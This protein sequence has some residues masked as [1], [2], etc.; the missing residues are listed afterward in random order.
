MPLPAGETSIDR[1]T[2]TARPRTDPPAA[3][4]D[5]GLAFETIWGERRPANALLAVVAERI[6]T[7]AA[8][9][10][11][12]R[13]DL[14]R[15]FAPHSVFEG[16]T[17]PLP[18]GSAQGFLI[19]ETHHLIQGM[20]GKGA[21]KMVFPEDFVGKGEPFVAVDPGSIEVRPPVPAE[22]WPDE[23]RPEE[24]VRQAMR[25]LMTGESLSMSL[26]CQATGA[27]FAGSEGLV[28]CAR[29]QFDPA[30]G[31]YFLRSPWRGTEAATPEDKELIESL[32]N[33]AAE[34][35]TRANRIA[36]DR[37]VHAAETN[38]TL[39]ARLS[40]DLPTN[41]VEGHLRALLQLSPETIIGDDDMTARLR[42][43]LARPDPSWTRCALA[44]AAARMQME[45]AILLPSSREKLRDS[46]AAL[47]ARGSPSPA[48][49]RQIVDLF[50]GT[51]EVQQNEDSL[52][53]HREPIL[54]VLS[55]ALSAHCLDE[56]GDPE[57]LAFYLKTLLDNQRIMIETILLRRLPP[58]QSLPVDWFE[59]AAPLAPHLEQQ[60]GAQLPAPPKTLTREEVADRFLTIVNLLFEALAKVPEDTPDPYL[61]ARREL[62]D[63]AIRA[64]TSTGDVLPSVERIVFF[65][66]PFTYECVTPKLGVV[67]RKPVEVCG[68][69]LRPEAMAVGAV[70]TIEILL[71]KL[72]RKS[73]PLEGLTVAIEGLGNAG[74]HVARIMA[75]RGASIVGVSDSR[76]AV[77]RPG[78]F[79]PAEL[80]LALAHKRAGKH[81]DTLQLPT[82]LGRSAEPPILFHPDPEALKRIQ[83]DVLILA[84]I[85][86][87]IEETNARQ[88]Q[89]SV[90]CELTGAAV[91]GAAKSILKERQI[92]VIPDNLASSGGLLVSLSE[93]LQ[94][95]VGQ[96]W[97]RRL[98]EHNLQEQL[99]RGYDAALRAAR[100]YDVD[101]ATASDIVALQ[102]M[103]ALAVYR[104]QL[105]TK[106]AQLAE[107]IRSIPPQDGVLLV[108]D[109]DE[110]G[111][112]SAAILHVLLTR[113]NPGLKDRVSLLSESFR[114][115][116]ILDFVEQQQHRGEPIRHLFVVDRS[117]PLSPQGQESL[118]AVARRCRM[119]FINNHDLPPALVA[120]PPAAGPS[121][122]TPLPIG[123][124]ELGIL[125]I[126]PQTLRA[127]IPARQFP[128]AL[129]LKE[130]AHR[131]VTDEATL[132]QINWQAAVGSC[133]DAPPDTTGEWLLF[134]SQFNP[135]KTIE[136]AR[137][138][139]TVTRAGGFR[140]AI[141]AL[142][143][144]ARPDQLS[145][146]QA[147]RGFMAEFRTLDERVQVLVEK[148]LLENRRKPY[149]AHFFTAD[150]VASPTRIAGNA[151][152][153]LDL[154]PWISERLTKYGNL[155]D[156]P[157]IV[158]QVV[159]DLKGSRFLGVRIRSPR[160]VELMEVGLPA[161]F[162][163]GGLPHTA[164]A[165]LPLDPVAPPRQVFEE[166]VDQ[167]WMKTTS[168]LYFRP[169]GLPKPSGQK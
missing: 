152:N 61:R 121:T 28:L 22:R 45:H 75:D 154:Y 103:Q 114:A 164:V 129:I 4:G 96:V 11:L 8:H 26:K 147:W 54:R 33:A 123:P 47:P 21:L 40:L 95:S 51:G 66:L 134:Y 141:Q 55:V 119:T 70:M 110:D 39:T 136:A 91:T 115:R 1:V 163:T 109:D 72:T 140:T 162:E 87:S 24:I 86:A 62:L 84:A 159:R 9:L 156:K 151:A 139:R 145:T 169:K 93:M 146:H 80:A 88:L 41:V 83:A 153:E 6:R 16:E 12:S 59:R 43:I 5:G 138:V 2:T 31:R 127:T 108:S 79:A 137:A 155:A 133:L 74:T 35:L 117:F 116:A 160:G 58:G 32:M 105:A 73:K 52:F 38:S 20:V 101:V 25:E 122:N 65:T 130:V 50:F 78:G 15:I 118:A 81:L 7:A 90:V 76:G 92:H 112:A 104:E 57:V 34:T 29:R 126:S 107:Q 60:L 10:G 89:V 14:W 42:E 27:P 106:S 102:R 161:D 17:A 97:H 71:R 111:V 18:P 49:Y 23:R 128:T 143:G 68:S 166:L 3:T 56:C 150:E 19:V 131:L 135:D 144:I 148:I 53:H 94:N 44:R 142:L 48:Q 46:L 30:S 98:E 77:I 120:T 99:S 36:Y 157:I 37:I 167:I 13:A 82:P 158:G 132:A 67:T 100:K 149:T 69:E 85:P 125:L 165:R 64:I 113:L 168:P 63:L 124:A